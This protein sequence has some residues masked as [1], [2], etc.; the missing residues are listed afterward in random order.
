MITANRL[1]DEGK[2]HHDKVEIDGHMK[3]GRI[4]KSN[5]VVYNQRYKLYVC[6][7]AETDSEHDLR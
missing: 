6:L 2:S 1:R 4:G 3:R 7:V 5:V